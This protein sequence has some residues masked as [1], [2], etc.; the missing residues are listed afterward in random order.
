MARHGLARRAAAAWASKERG[1]AAA[2]AEQLGLGVA[3]EGNCSVSL[4]CFPDEP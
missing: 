2:A 4:L 1:C 3:C